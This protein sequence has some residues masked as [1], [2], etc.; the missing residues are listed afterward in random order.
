MSSQQRIEDGSVACAMAAAVVVLNWQCG[1]YFS[2]TEDYAMGRVTEAVRAGLRGA[3][4]HALLLGEAEYL[5]S[6]AEKCVQLDPS[7]AFG[8]S[9][10]DIEA[11]MFV[12][13]R[14][15]AYAFARSQGMDIAAAPV[16]TFV[17]VAVL[18]DLASKVLAE[19]EH[20]GETLH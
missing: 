1:D 13:E 6:I 3:V 2:A 4:L 17:K 14:A 20:A 16:D 8:E 10:E 18:S 12:I 15:G 19:H 7:R 9:A 11:A 5:D